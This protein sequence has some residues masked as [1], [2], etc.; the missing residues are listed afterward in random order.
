MLENELSKN[1]IGDSVNATFRIPADIIERLRKE[2]ESKQSSLNAIVNQI[3]RKYVDWEFFEAK[4][5]L[6]PFPK[7]V[8]ADIFSSLE[9]DRIT[10]LATGVGKKAAI[11]MSIFMS[12][13]LNAQ[14]FV[15]CLELRLLHSG[16]E[17]VR[18]AQD[19][20]ST[21]IVKHDL[22]KN[23]SFYLEALVDSALEEMLGQKPDSFSTDSIVSVEYKA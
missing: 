16:C 20:Q 4:V 17:V 3:L 1:C 8:L 15:S 11:E 22:G 9:Q 21:I 10:S 7:Q 19:G 6:V 2:S 23:W 12:G 14:A 18:R 5:G 13:K